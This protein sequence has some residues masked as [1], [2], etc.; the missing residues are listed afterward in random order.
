MSEQARQAG[1]QIWLLQGNHEQYVFKGKIKSVEPEHLWAIEQLMP[2]EEAFSQHSVLGRWMRSQPVILKLDNFLF[3]HGGISETVLNSGLTINALNEHYHNTLTKKVITQ[4]EHNLF[5]SSN[6]LTFYRGLTRGVKAGNL[7][8]A[9]LIKQIH[10]HFKTTYLV[11]GHTHVEEIE[12][13][14]EMGFI[15]VETDDNSNHVLV[16]KGGQPKLTNISVV[17]TNF[18]DQHPIK[19]KFDFSNKQDWLALVPDTALLNRAEEAG[20]FFKGKI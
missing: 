15:N 1:G 18:I 16:I 12:L 7:S 13:D 5:Y 9:E 19:R 6:G 4:Q 17:K 14:K 11:V 2:Y 10:H 20:K 3:T 8:K